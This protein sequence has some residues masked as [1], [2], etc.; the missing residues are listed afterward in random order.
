M[1]DKK[2]TLYWR[3]GDR[4]VVEGS[5]IANAFMRA[6]Y[7]GGAIRALDFHAEGDDENYAWNGAEREWNRI[8]PLEGHPND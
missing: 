3:T 6:G 2:L 7:G 8:T 4:E 1:E 5:D